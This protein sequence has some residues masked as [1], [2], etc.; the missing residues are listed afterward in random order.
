MATRSRV[1]CGMAVIWSHCVGTKMHIVTSC[2]SISRTAAA[3][4][5]PVVGVMTAF[6]PR[7]RNGSIPLIPPMWKSGW[8]D[9]QTSSAVAPIS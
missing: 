1:A 8:P 5:K 6:A 3:G 7:A 4:S 9:S 2:S